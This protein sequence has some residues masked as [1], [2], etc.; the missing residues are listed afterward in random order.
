MGGAAFTTRAVS[1]VAN[2]AGLPTSPTTDLEEA[3][4]ARGFS[5]IAGIDEVGRGPLAGPVVAAAVILPRR[6]S[7]PW[8]QLVRDS[9]QLTPGQRAEAYIHLVAAA[10]TY[11]LGACSPREI[12]RIGI[13]S[14]TRLAMAR[15]VEMLD[16]QPDHLLIDAL[17]LPALPVSQTP[18]IKGDSLSLS[19]AAASIIAKV[20][21]DRLMSTIF[22]ERFP[23]YGFA[24]HKGY[25]TP[26]HLDALR[27]IGP[28][29]IHRRTFRP[30]C[31]I[32]GHPRRTE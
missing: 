32:L 11:G 5:N 14:A 16:P 2:T 29:S 7:A 12:D 17:P 1:T 27:R 10:R 28:S 15:A 9:K 6:L 18:V 23:G 3:L 30:V 13:A 26:D 19:I 8:V 25:P 24:T 31:D 21:R 4:F 22:E 20:T